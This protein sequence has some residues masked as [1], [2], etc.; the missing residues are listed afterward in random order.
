VDSFVE[1]LKLADLGLGNLGM[2]WFWPNWLVWETYQDNGLF[3]QP[4][5]A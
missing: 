3:Y 1:E 2:G 5:H 4:K